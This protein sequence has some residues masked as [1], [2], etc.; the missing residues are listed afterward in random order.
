MTMKASCELCL[1]AGL[2]PMFIVVV[3]YI[4]F[5]QNI[6]RLTILPLGV[7]C[8]AFISQNR[9]LEDASGPMSGPDVICPEAYCRTIGQ[10]HA[11]LY[12]TYALFSILHD[13]IKHNALYEL[14]INHSNLN[15]LQGTEN[16]ETHPEML[17][18]PPNTLV[19]ELGP[20]RPETYGPGV[21][22]FENV[23]CLST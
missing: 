9:S 2:Q 19:R 14:G 21:M 15:N 17:V 3:L 18:L 23:T 16:D 13:S 5:D 8:F 11:F 12:I 7:N 20:K 1:V 22:N 4:L 10:D 6:V